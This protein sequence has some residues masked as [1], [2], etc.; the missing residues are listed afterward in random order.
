MSFHRDNHYVPQLYLKRF[1]SAAGKLWKYDILVADGRYPEWKP[2]SI[3]GSAYHVHLYT[4]IASGVESDEVETWLSDEFERPVEESL[5][6]ATSNGR[7]TPDDWERLVRFLAAQ[8]VRTPARLMEMLQRWNGEP[9]QKIL[10]DSLAD[11][12]EKLKAAAASGCPVPRAEVPFAEYLPLRTK[13]EPAPEQ[14]MVRL[15]VEVVLG[16]GFFLYMVRHLLT[17]TLKVL[18]GHKWTI[19]VSPKDRIWF[20]SDDPVIKLNYADSRNYDFGGGWGRSGTEIFLPLDPR[21]LLYTQV[22]KRPPQRGS[23]MNDSQA[24]LTR[25]MIAEHAHRYVFAPAPIVEVAK[26]HPRIVNAAFLQEENEQWRKWH[27][28]Q[29]RAEA[30]LFAGGASSRTLE[31]SPGQSE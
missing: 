10:D 23:V 30:E 31:G 25:R 8:D 29:V 12:V 15:G 13:R 6:R 16:R 3:R 14:G 5:A 19:L 4:R 9:M 27:E 1:A 28:E 11:T 17:Q 18:L 7:L 24:A 2:A 20:T 26:L 21:H 22:G